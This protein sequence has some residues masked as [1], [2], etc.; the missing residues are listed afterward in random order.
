L[1]KP[2]ARA[3]LLALLLCTPVWAQRSSITVVCNG[4]P[5][6]SSILVRNGLEYCP[7]DPIAQALH[8]SV[9]WNP[10]TKELK[11]AD[12][13]VI[14]EPLYVGGHLYLPVDAIAEAGN[15]NS[16]WDT[17]RSVAT[18]SSRGGVGNLDPSKVQTGY[19]PSMDGRLPTNW[20]FANPLAPVAAPVGA[21]APAPDAA[22]LSREE[23][24]TGDVFIPKAVRNAAFQVTVTNLERLTAFR[25]Y[26]QPKGGCRF[27]VVYLSEKNVS[28]EAQVNPG[29][30]YVMDQQGTS[31]QAMED[32]SSFW[33]VI[34]R[35]YG[36]N[37]GYLVYEIPEERIPVSIVL[38]STGN[39]PLSLNL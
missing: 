14:A 34:M 37:F 1:R 12:N 28:S 16:S 6:Q 22:V 8:L 36:V 19:D 5:V 30:F 10:G 32:L 17:S 20:Q 24:R 18:L 4:T 27:V 25:G 21:P 2:L 39:S 3:T 29:R 35:P 31:Y 38:T 11:I 23:N 13:L 7:V 15:C 33:P 9:S 26:Y